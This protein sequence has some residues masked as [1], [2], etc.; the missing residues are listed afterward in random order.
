MWVNNIV[1]SRALWI[2]YNPLP[3]AILTGWC[4][5]S[6]PRSRV[7]WYLHL[8]KCPDVIRI[9]SRPVIEHDG[10]HGLITKIIKFGHWLVLTILRSHFMGSPTA[11]LSEAGCRRAYGHYPDLQRYQTEKWSSDWFSTESAALFASSPTIGA[12]N[13][14]S[15]WLVRDRIYFHAHGI[16]SMWDH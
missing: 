1:T 3:D 4:H 15:S 14:Y 7:S 10:I 9:R 6:V 11:T 16:I 5:L 8:R 12:H 2:G 13:F